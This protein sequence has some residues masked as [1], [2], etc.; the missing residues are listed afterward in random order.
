MPTL[1]PHTGTDPSGS[2]H[3]PGVG[4]DGT[5]PGRLQDRQSKSTQLVCKIN[6]TRFSTGRPPTSRRGKCRSEPP[7]G[8]VMQNRYFAITSSHLNQHEATSQY[9]K[10]PK[11][12]EFKARHS[13]RR[14]RRTAARYSRSPRGRSADRGGD[15]LWSKTG[16]LDWWMKERQEWWGRVRGADGRQRWIRA[17]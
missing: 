7:G 16:Q 1:A 9:L 3:P 15:G 12:T 13:A 8:E 6:C 14:H 5:E 11:P 2:R 4:H 17:V 10:S